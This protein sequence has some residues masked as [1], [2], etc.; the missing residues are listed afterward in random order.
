MERE[1]KR[2]SVVSRYEYKRKETQAGCMSFFVREK[3][4][5]GRD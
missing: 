1:G 2:G 3:V 4:R 5:K